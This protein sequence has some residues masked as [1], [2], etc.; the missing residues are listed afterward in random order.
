MA[1]ADTTSQILLNAGFEDVSLCRCDREFRFGM[2]L[3]KGVEL[4]M[5]LGPAGEVIRLAG[6]EAERIRPQIEAALREALSEF[7]TPDGVRALSSTWIVSAVA[8][9]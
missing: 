8:P 6:A 7:A 5:A 2:S 1:D 3:E 4:V 9:A